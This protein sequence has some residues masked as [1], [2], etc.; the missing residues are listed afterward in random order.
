MQHATWGKQQVARSDTAVGVLVTEAEHCFAAEDQ[1]H[2]FTARV[3]VWDG[4]VARREGGQ[5]PACGRGAN[6]WFA[7]W[8]GAHLATHSVDVQFRQI[9]R[10]GG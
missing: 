5:H 4:D 10:L 9:Q 7:P 3:E 8:G 6:Q 2:L 1:K